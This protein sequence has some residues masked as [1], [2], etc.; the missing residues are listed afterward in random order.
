M[1]NYDEYHFNFD[2]IEHDTLLD[3]VM[4]CY[5]STVASVR[6]LQSLPLRQDYRYRLLRQQQSYRRQSRSCSRLE[7]PSSA[8]TKGKVI[9]KS[10]RRTGA[11]GVWRLYQRGQDHSAQVLHRK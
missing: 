6:R 7:S 5:E 11:D 4:F 8:G 1:H 3:V 10:H 2:I 9:A